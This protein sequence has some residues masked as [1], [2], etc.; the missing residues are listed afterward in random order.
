MA[1]TGSKHCK[2][3]TRGSVTEQ[4]VREKQIEGEREVENKD[5]G[6]RKLENREIGREDGPKGR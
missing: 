1:A 2:S 4:E 3:E 6:K 5:R